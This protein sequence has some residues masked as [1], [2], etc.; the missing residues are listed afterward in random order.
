[1][2]SQAAFTINLIVVFNL[3]LPAG[4]QVGL[5]RIED[6]LVGALISLVVGV[7]LWPRGAHREV[8]RTLGSLI[9]AWF[10]S[11]RTRSI[12]S[13]D[14]RPPSQPLPAAA[15]GGNSRP[16]GPTQLGRW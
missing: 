9:A 3:I 4:W 11:G 2:L 10:R 13:L 16:T 8:G 15:G 7:L 12:A 6:V 1:M 14:S 5:V